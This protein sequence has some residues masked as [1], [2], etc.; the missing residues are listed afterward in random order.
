MMHAIEGVFRAVTTPVGPDA[1]VR[2]DLLVDHCRRAA[3]RGLSRHRALGH[4]RRGRTASP[5]P[6]AGGAGGLI[7]AG[8]RGDQ[9]L[10]GT[11]S[12][13]IPETVELTRHAVAHGV[14]GCVM[15]PPFY[16]KGVG[17]EGLFRFYASVIEGVADD[18]LRVMLYT[19]RRY[20]RS[21]SVSI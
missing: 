16:Y 19:F 6:N 2:L 17:D 5:S 18:R 13:N 3:G 7:A 10:P 14:S 1:S 4:D 12:C 15:L 11:S 20:R 9:L 21:R 8:I